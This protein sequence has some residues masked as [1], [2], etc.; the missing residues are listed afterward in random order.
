MTDSLAVHRQ[1]MHMLFLTCIDILTRLYEL[2]ACIY[3]VTRC[4]DHVSHFQRHVLY[5]INNHRIQA[6]HHVSTHTQLHK[7][8]AYKNSLIQD[9]I[10]ILCLHLTPQLIHE[11]RSLTL[12]Q[13]TGVQ[14]CMKDTMNKIQLLVY[15]MTMI[16][17]QRCTLQMTTKKHTQSDLLPSTLDEN[18]T[19][20]QAEHII[21]LADGIMA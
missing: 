21:G 1:S 18:S 7:A 8:D 16:H 3:H 14:D 2:T 5:I 9:G 11:L 4:I 17:E 12:I 6:T 13:A 15:R 10:R 20:I 19:W